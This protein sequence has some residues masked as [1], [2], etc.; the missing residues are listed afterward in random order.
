[1][2][3]ET[4]YILACE[5]F[6][7]EIGALWPELEAAAAPACLSCRYLDQELHKDLEALKGA[8][9]GALQEISADR[10]ILLYGSKCH[11]EMPILAAGRRIVTLEEVNCVHAISGRDTREEPRA[12]FLTPR[13]LFN[14]RRFFRYDEKTDEEK[15]IFREKFCTYC[16][17]AVFYDTGVM[18]Y[19][20][21]LL[22]DFA[23]ASGLTTD[24]VHIGLEPFRKKMLLAVQKALA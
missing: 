16:N 14:W 6:R 22:Y 18:A 19:S 23:A 4:I 11:P 17:T 13:E 1:M 15:E 7:L 5:A 3:P 20:G 21:E 9:E 12:F 8:V 2:K 10:V 24:R